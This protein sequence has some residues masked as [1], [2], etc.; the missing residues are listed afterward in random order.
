V[1]VRRQEV[2]ETISKTWPLQA[3]ARLISARR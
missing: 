3:A 2:V 1:G